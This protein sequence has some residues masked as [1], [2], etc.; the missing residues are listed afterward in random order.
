MKME[1]LSS[2]SASRATPQISFGSDN[3]NSGAMYLLLSRKTLGER[4]LSH[5]VTQG[6]KSQTLIFPCLA[7]HLG[8]NHKR[9][10]SILIETGLSYL[11]NISTK[12]CLICWVF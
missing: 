3:A 1:G 5:S 9:P 10:I 12:T 6:G 8:P 11:A 7:R 2:M 4:I